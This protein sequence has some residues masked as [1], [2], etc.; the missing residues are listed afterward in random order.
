MIKKRDLLDRVVALECGQHQQEVI[1][2]QQLETNSNLGGINGRQDD[3][4]EKVIGRLEKLE[5]DNKQL[6]KMLNEILD[7]LIKDQLDSAFEHLGKALDGLIAE[8]QKKEQP[9]QE[10]R[11]RG[12]P[13]KE[14]K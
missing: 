9:K 11:G 3:F 10:K 12:R 14:S 2:K 7:I 4:N 8:Q 1:N 5:K 13:R 6:H